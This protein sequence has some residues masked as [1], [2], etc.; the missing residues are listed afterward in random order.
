MRKQKIRLTSLVVRIFYLGGPGEF[1]AWSEVIFCTLCFL[2]EF[3]KFVDN[4]SKVWKM[5]LIRLI[6]W[7]RHP[8]LLNFWSMTW[9]I[10]KVKFNQN[11]KLFALMVLYPIYF[12]TIHINRTKNSYLRL[13]LIKW[14]KPPIFL[15][16]NFFD[17][18]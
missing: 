3:L 8:T 11:G 15:S 18:M 14:R 1:F 5:H 6:C 9:Q 2:Y 13:F 7:V 16:N 17:R 4:F 10:G 12:S